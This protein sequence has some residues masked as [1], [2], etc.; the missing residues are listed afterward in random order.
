M[1]GS[2]QRGMTR[3]SIGVSAWKREGTET[4]IDA[5]VVAL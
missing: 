5:R 3:A 2:F 4:P 1:G